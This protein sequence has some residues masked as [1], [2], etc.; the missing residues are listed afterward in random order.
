MAI[1]PGPGLP[2][3]LGKPG[4]VV[5]VLKLPEPGSTV[6]E[7]VPEDFTYVAIPNNKV[8]PNLAKQGIYDVRY[9]RNDASMSYFTPVVSRAVIAPPTFP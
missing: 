2:A 7:Q 1:E 8:A 6:I 4:L 3:V 9:L 5:L